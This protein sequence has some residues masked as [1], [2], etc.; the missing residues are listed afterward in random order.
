MQTYFYRLSKPEIEFLEEN[1]NLT[2]DEDTLLKMASRRCS[3]VQIA[4]RLGVSLSTVT[5]RKKKISVKIINFVE[6]LTLITTI[7]INGKRVTKDEIKNYE[8]EIEKVK[9]ILSEKLTKKS[10]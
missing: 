5:K 6:G 8:I 3:D 1:C 4:D 10:K 7:Y 9:E 2:E